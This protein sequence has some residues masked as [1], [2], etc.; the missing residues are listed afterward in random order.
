MS[1]PPGTV[2]LRPALPASR[3]LP[4]CLPRAGWALPET[5]RMFTP[6]DGGLRDS[7]LAGEGGR[8]E[9]RSF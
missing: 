8:P 1:G 4:K 9:A 7:I 6:R 2:I 3:R 5:R